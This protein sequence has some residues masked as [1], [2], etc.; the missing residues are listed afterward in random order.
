MAYSD[1]QGR[2]DY[3]HPFLF[4]KSL[5]GNGITSL[6]RAGC[7]HDA[8]TLGLARTRDHAQKFHHS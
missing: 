1:E 2:N 7:L 8:S 3:A 5:A 4:P 6:R